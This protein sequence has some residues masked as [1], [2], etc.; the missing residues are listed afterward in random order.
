MGGM[1][2]TL[3]PYRK[4]LIVFFLLNFF[5]SQPNSYI[6]VGLMQK[7]TVRSSK[8]RELRNFEI[9]VWSHRKAHKFVI[10]FSGQFSKNLN[11][12]EGA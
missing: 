1:D 2:S 12:F 3:P 7:D 8:L 5:K 10:F 4:P 6:I 11:I 9:L